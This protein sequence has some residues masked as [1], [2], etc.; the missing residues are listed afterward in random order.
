MM[1]KLTSAPRRSA[2]AIGLDIGSG[3]VRAAEVTRGRRGSVLRHFAQVGL[4]F[5]AVVDGE[6]VDPGA[7]ITALRRL[8]AEGGFS[9]RNVVLA[10]SGQ[11]VIVRQAEVVSMSEGDFRS[12]LRFQAPDLIPIPI[13]DAVLDF[14]IIPDAGGQPKQADRM[15]V[16]LAAAHRGFVEA[17]VRV[18]REAS[19]RI[20]AV[21]P[22]P[23]AA[24]RAVSRAGIAGQQAAAIV[25]IGADLTLV[26][27]REAGRVRFS[28]T[29]GTG[30]SDLTKRL[31]GRLR[32]D[33]AQAEAMKRSASGLGGTGTLLAEEVDPLVSEVE[34]SLAFF[35]SQLGTGPH[36]LLVTGG[37]SRSPQLV[38]D[39]D[40][41][42]PGPV[43]I[44]DPFAGLDCPDLDLDAAARWA[45]SSA[46]LLSIGAAEWS[47]DRPSERLSL[48]PE[49]FAVAAAARRK[50]VALAAGVAV[51]AGGL[52]FL[53]VHRSGQVSNER[54]LA[55]TVVAANAVAQGRI[56]Q[57]QPVSQVTAA[58]Q[59]RLGILKADQSGNVA[60]VQLIGEISAALP[61]GATLTTITLTGVGSA[62]ASSAGAAS[63]T[64]GAGVTSG[65]LGGV[66]MSVQATGTLDQVAVWLRALRR[67]PS[68]DNVVVA[69]ASAAGTSV[70]FSSTAGISALAPIVQRTPGTAG[71]P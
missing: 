8:W 57:L 38:A 28:R 52:A 2:S 51:V 47:F 12:A 34:D 16:L 65:P 63:S 9:S 56:N 42:I 44:L 40:R 13:D 69:S 61:K 26:T 22:A 54:A 5:G 6:I 53:G 55:A 10:L 11:R 15:Q 32:T 62:T 48:L 29:L 4:P 17:H 35:N 36:G 68:L 19:L 70:T 24:V 27:V 3:A 21:D 30:G 33:H 58:V 60:W 49:G 59:S 64:G 18:L 41:R 45:A 46:S 25:D 50:I 37:P 39:L 67:V 14:V 31:A 20:V 7:V 1:N 71:A 43:G 23:M 66:T